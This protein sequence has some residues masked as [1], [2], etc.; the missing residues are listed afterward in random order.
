[1]PS[2]ML[3]FASATPIATGAFHGR[4]AASRLSSRARIT[5]RRRAHCAIH[6]SAAPLSRRHF[7]RMVSALAVG[8]LLHPTNASAVAAPAA[9]GSRE[10]DEQYGYSFATPA[11]GWTRSTASLSSFRTATVYVCDNDKDANISMVVTPVPGD[12]QKLTS[13]GT[14]DNILVRCIF[15]DR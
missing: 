13:F 10:I 9:L 4:D 11:S 6:C 1:M 14:I 3:A 8:V 15:L 7:T 2:A 5:S 12:F